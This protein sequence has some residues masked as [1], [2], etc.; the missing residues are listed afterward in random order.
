MSRSLH[1][2]VL[3]VSSTP[4]GIVSSQF[5]FLSYPPKA[6][7]LS[8]ASSIYLN[9]L[10]LALGRHWMAFLPPAQGSSKAISLFYLFRLCSLV[11]VSPSCALGYSNF[12]TSGYGFCY[13]AA[14]HCGP[15][16]RLHHQVAENR[17]AWLLLG[18]CCL[19]LPHVTATWGPHPRVCLKRSSHPKVIHTSVACVPTPAMS[20]L[21]PCPARA[22]VRFPGR[23]Q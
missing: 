22:W 10:S 12:A 18:A 8:S 14:G 16:V 21:C 5:P 3:S 2:L 6:D 15:S 7:V 19:V 20:L 1:L 9:G 11:S 13:F 17:L 23:V 4:L